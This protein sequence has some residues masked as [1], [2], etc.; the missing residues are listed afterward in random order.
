MA[1]TIVYFVDSPVFGGSEQV[2]LHLLRRLDRT[3]WQP[4][5]FHHPAKELDSFLEEVH[6][7][8][9]RTRAVPR[10]QGAGAIRNFYPFLHHL[11][12]EQ[13]TIFHA[14]LS[15]LLSCKFGL[16]AAA[17]ARVPIVIATLHQ[18]LMPPWKRNIY[19]QQRLLTP[20]VHLYTAVSQAVAQQLSQSFQVPSR[21]IRVIYNGIPTASYDETT[22][23]GPVSQRG[24]KRPIVLTVARLDAQKGHKF[25]LDAITQIPDAHFL[26]A[27]EGAEQAGL[28]AQARELGIGDRLSFLGYRS[29]V[30]DLLASCDLFVLPSLYEGFPLSVLEAMAAGKPV[31]ATA[32]GGTPE[33]VIDQVTG[34]IVPP[35][36]AN[37]LAGAI[38]KVLSNTA[39]AHAM[40]MAGKERVQ[41]SFTVDTMANCY[42]Q[43]YEDL[44]NALHVMPIPWQLSVRPRGL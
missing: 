42:N 28:Q 7:L 37:S 43:I 4:V 17:I 2:L 38:R 25:L 10:L 13:P 35:G 26:L 30:P 11:R 5:L 24:S 19:W 44:L 33:A 21:K 31:V 8:N 39:L 32:V 22:T 27:G 15:W 20:N 34:Y 12:T 14:H 41:A 6:K 9:V 16:L 29:D 23:R 40:G 3:R 18:F 36:D 1:Q